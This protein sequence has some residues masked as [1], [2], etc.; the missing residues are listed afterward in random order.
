M[1]K[2]KIFFQ[3]ATGLFFAAVSFS[4]ASS[5]TLSRVD[6]YAAIPFMGTWTDIAATGDTFHYNSVDQGW[7]TIVMPFDFPYD[8]TTV[9]AGTKINVGAAGAISLSS[10]TVPVISVLDSAG[11]PGYVCVFSGTVFEGTGHA[12]PA[13]SDYYEVDGIA[14]NRVLTVEYHFMHMPGSGSGT[15]GGG[16]GGG[17]GGSGGNANMVQVK[18]YETTGVIEFI[19]Q[20]HNSAFESGP[21][22]LC[23]IGLNGFSSPKFLANTYATNMIATPPTDLRWMPGT[24]IS[25]SIAIAKPF[26]PFTCMLSRDT[27]TIIVKNTGAAA[28]SYQAAIS[29]GSTSDFTIFSPNPSPS[30]P[31]GGTTN[32]QI[33]FNPSTNSQE[34][35][36]FLIASAQGG[37]IAFNAMGG[38]AEIEGF[39]TADTTPVGRIDTFK[40]VLQNSGSCDWTPGTPSLGVPFWFVSGANSVVP[41]GETD[42][43]TFAFAPPADSSYS[44]QVTFPNAIGVSI[45]APFVELSGVAAPAAGVQMVSAASGYR[46]DQNYP[47]PFSGTSHCELTLPVGGAVT[48]RVIDLQGQVVETLLD[49]HFDAGSFD[50]TLDAAGLASGTYFYQITAGGNTL[51]RQMVI[52]R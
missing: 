32:F 43:L 52:A 14:P 23:N 42:T 27:A 16:K 17:G 24:I 8:S 31:A 7:G 21:G 49:R 38:A 2:L 47:N 5:Q 29:G 36:N 10:D 40:V 15:G 19:Y 22:I 3:F 46:L 45:P 28:A 48:L 18:F 26:A 44:T 11:Y 4:N 30:V 1:N 9:K 33:A 37:S 12:T 50:V 13:D 51:T 41:S 35:A 25:D 20:A 6:H 34:N 39:G